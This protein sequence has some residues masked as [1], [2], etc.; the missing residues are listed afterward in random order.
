[1]SFFM[2]YIYYVLCHCDNIGQFCLDE[3][4]N[5]TFLLVS[6]NFILIKYVL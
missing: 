2:E 1:M 6:Y 5:F 3:S 4:L